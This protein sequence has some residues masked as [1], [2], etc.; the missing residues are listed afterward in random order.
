MDFVQDVTPEV[1]SA[2]YGARGALPTLAPLVI[3]AAEEAASGEPALEVGRHSLAFFV[4]PRAA[5]PE[6]A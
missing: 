3:D 6:C 1:V 4:F 5:A 2:R